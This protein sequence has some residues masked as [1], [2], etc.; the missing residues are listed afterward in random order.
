[1]GFKSSE[2]IILVRCLV[3]WEMT[4]VSRGRT[5]VRESEFVTILVQ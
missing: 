2:V 4:D 5:G 3:G 1:M